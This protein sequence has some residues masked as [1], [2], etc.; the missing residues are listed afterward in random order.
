M[1][2]QTS[3][4]SK[5]I[6]SG[7]KMVPFA[8]WDMPLHYG[9]QIEEHHQVRQDAGVFDVSHMVVTDIC[10]KQASDFLRYLLANDVAKLKIPGKALYSCML[11]ETGGIVDDLIV[12]YLSDQ[13]YRL[14]TNAGTRVK[15]LAWIQRYASSFEVEIQ[16]QTDL[17]ILAIQG[18]HAISKLAHV[19]PKDRYVQIRALR[20]FEVMEYNQHCIS[21]TGYTGEDGVEVLTPTSIVTT[22]WDNILAADIKPCGLGA[23]DTLRLEAGLNLYGADMDE[24]TTPFE[25]NLSWTVALEPI[26]RE[27][28]GREALQAQQGNIQRRLVGLVLEQRGVLR[29][30]QKVIVPQIGEGEVTSGSFSPTLQQAIALA[31]VPKATGNSCWV[32]IR[33]EQIPAKVIRPPFVRQGKQAYSCWSETNT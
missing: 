6:E 14:V 13:H 22:L 21:R 5:H 25:S 26:D 17:A 11:N 12:Y 30:H 24:A 9:S 18:P 32:E 27:F 23:R 28:I 16:L 15:D 33:G 2:Q 31:R 1:G 7:G 10:G 20:P 8:G 29:N 19:F 3:L 4:Y